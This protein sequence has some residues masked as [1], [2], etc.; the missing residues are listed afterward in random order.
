MVVVIV[1]WLFNGGFALRRIARR[2]CLLLHFG[3]TLH[4]P[5]TIARKRCLRVFLCFDCLIVLS[6]KARLIG[7]AVMLCLFNGLKYMA[8]YR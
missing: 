3:F 2:S 1:V 5:A 7:R 6:L 8:G 4:N